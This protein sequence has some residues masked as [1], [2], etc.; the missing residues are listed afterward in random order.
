MKTSNFFL[1]FIAI[2]AMIIVS[3]NIIAQ[4]NTSPTQ[5]VCAGSVAEPYLIN[6]PS[7][8]STY[9]WSISGGG[10][11]NLSLIHISEPTRPY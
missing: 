3:N 6:P 10:V 11:L 7:S 8:G 1:R 2:F 5:N 9:Q 4:T